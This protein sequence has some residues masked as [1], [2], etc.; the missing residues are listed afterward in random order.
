MT[1]KEHEFMVLMFARMKQEMGMI[2]ELLKSRGVMTE[3]DHRAFG[4]LVWDDPQKMVS[5]LTAS[6]RDYNRCARSVGI[7]VPS[8]FPPSD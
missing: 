8:N 6:L 5:Y 3:D 1:D 2:I 4:H 7:Q